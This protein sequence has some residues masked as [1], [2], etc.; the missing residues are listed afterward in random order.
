MDREKLIEHIRSFPNLPAAAQIGMVM[1]ESSES[2]GDELVKVSGKQF[3][4]VAEIICTLFNL[5]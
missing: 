1:R 3:E 2:D 5:K 4:V